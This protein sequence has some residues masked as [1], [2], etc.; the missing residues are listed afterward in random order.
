MG[1]VLLPKIL[2]LNDDGA[3]LPPADFEPKGEDEEPNV[4]APKDD[5]VFAVS[6][7]VLGGERKS[8]TVAVEPKA[9]FGGLER[10]PEAGNENPEEGGAAVLSDFIPTSGMDGFPPKG[11]KLA[12][13]FGIDVVT[14]EEV[15]PVNPKDCVDVGGLG[16]SSKSFCTDSRKFL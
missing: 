5:V 15:D 6:V 9:D 3:S 13:G 7:E 8:G 16:F 4:L 11:A 10:E 2:L 12:G 1:F 14:A